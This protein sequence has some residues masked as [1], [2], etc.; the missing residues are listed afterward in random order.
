MTVYARV[1]ERFEQ[2]NCCV[3][4]ILLVGLL[5]VRCASREGSSRLPDPPAAS[6][7]PVP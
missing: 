6:Q 4:S 7:K 3:V 5:S 1:V 2:R